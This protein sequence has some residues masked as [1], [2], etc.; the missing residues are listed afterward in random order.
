MPYTFYLAGNNGLL[1]L[2][3]QLKIEFPRK[4]DRFAFIQKEVS[5]KQCTRHLGFVRI[6]LN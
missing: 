6:L 4:S 1:Y 3:F 2:T 5:A